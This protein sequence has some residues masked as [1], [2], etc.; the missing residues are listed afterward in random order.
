MPHILI[1]K[2]D[3]EGVPPVTENQ[4]FPHQLCTLQDVRKL[5]QKPFLHSA[6]IIHHKGIKAYAGYRK[7]QAAVS[8]GSIKGIHEPF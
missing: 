8:P 2:T 5:I 4:F 7:K 1:I 3:P 6:Y